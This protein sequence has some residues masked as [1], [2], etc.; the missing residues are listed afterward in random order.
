[1]RLRYS[2]N[3]PTTLN[4]KNTLVPTWDYDHHTGNIY[5]HVKTWNTNKTHNIHSLML[6]MISTV[7]PLYTVVLNCPYQYQHFPKAEFLQK[8]KHSNLCPQM[9]VT[10][11][12]Q[13][14]TSNTSVQS[15]SYSQGLCWF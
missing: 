6:F 5:I 14:I 13:L 1:M 9:S 11:I 2:M 12:S 3:V 4:K 15:I 10:S 8:H 7:Y